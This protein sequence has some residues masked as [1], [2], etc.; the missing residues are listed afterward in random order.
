MFAANNNRITS[1]VFACMS[2]YM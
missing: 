1:A 2:V